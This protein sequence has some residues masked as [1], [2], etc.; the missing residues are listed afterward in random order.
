MA[1]SNTNKPQLPNLS[2]AI[3][4]GKYSYLWPYT[5]KIVN[6]RMVRTKGKKS[7]GSIQGGGQTGLVIWKE[8]FLAQYPEL[9]AFDVYRVE[10]KKGDQ[11]TP[12]E[13]DF[14]FVDKAKNSGLNHRKDIFQA[15]A[16]W[17][18]DQMLAN[19]PLLR[20]LNNTFY[21]DQ[22]ASKIISLA[23]FVLLSRSLDFNNY[24]NGVGSIRL[25]FPKALTERDINLFLKEISDVQI[26]KFFDE[27]QYRYGERSSLNQQFYVIE[28]SYPNNLINNL[29]QGHKSLSCSNNNLH[30]AIKKDTQ[31]AR[32]RTAKVQNALSTMVHSLDDRAFSLVSSSNAMPLFSATYN[33]HNFSLADVLLFCQHRVLVPINKRDFNTSKDHLSQEYLEASTGGFNDIKASDTPDLMSYIG[34]FSD[35]GQ[36]F[37]LSQFELNYEHQESLSSFELNTLK[38]SA[39]AGNALAGSTPAGCALAGGAPDNSSLASAEPN[40]SAGFGSA[41]AAAASATHDMGAG[42]GSGAGAGAGAGA[43]KSLKSDDEGSGVSKPA[44]LASQALRSPLSKKLG[45]KVI[46]NASSNA[47][48]STGFSSNLAFSAPTVNN[49]EPIVSQT[50]A[51]QDKDN[52]ANQAYKVTL[53][54]DSHNKLLSQLCSL[55]QNKQSFMLRITDNN[56]VMN[57]WADYFIELLITNANYSGDNQEFSLNTDLTLSFTDPSLTQVIKG[58][59]GKLVSINKKVRQNITLNIKL[60]LGSLFN[61]LQEQENSLLNPEEG[62]GDTLGFWDINRCLKLS[63]LDKQKQIDDK[64]EQMLSEIKDDSSHADNFSKATLLKLKRLCKYLLKL[65]HQALP[66]VLSNNK[67]SMDQACYAH[68]LLSAKEQFYDFMSWDIFKVERL[69]FDPFTYL[70]RPEISQLLRAKLFILFISSSLYSMIQCATFN[71]DQS[72]GTNEVRKSLGFDNP[73]QY[74]KLVNSISAERKSEGLIYCD[75]NM[76]QQSLLEYLDINAPAKESFDNVNSDSQVAMRNYETHNDWFS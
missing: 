50:V 61:Q 60:D 68:Q 35:N 18:L 39:L 17:V 5:T 54:S 76:E 48:N 9:K 57:H 55:C 25:P 20:A 71:K 64:L 36:I 75:L 47:A 15:G 42:S 27:L 7:V 29:V 59:S 56:Y 13:Y 33:S 12:G 67:V 6:G 28:H 62:Y 16:T 31:Q 22:S 51:K 49:P 45:S 46:T 24:I 65:N 69:M 63:T 66:I 43:E 41:A 44:L 52:E 14:V 30:N 26:A 21:K 58:K 38:S 53:I 70:M 8:E 2:V 37:S 3:V 19:T 32:W 73:D 23:Y 1:I 74:L 34:S 10:L 4:N 72:Y 40:T 11:I